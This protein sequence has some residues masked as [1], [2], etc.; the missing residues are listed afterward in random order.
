MPGPRLD[1][2]AAGSTRHSNWWVIYN[3]T[4]GGPR[5]IT[6]A[7]YTV[8]M[9]TSQPQRYV[10]GPFSSKPAAQ[11][12]ITNASNAGGISIPNPLNIVSGWLGSLGGMIGSGIESGFVSFFKD[13]WDV[14]VGPLEILLGVLIGMWVLVIYFKNDIMSVIG[15]AGGIAKAV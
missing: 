12:Y 1:P 8:V 4:A 15:A 6:P 11:T 10:A 14:I 3:M 7:D 5:N 9:A 13:L 2:H